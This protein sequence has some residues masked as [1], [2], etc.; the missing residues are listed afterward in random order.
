MIWSRLSFG[1]AV[2]TLILTGCSAT[3]ESASQSSF[4]KRVGPI[5]VTNP[6]YVEHTFKFKNPTARPLSVLKVDKSCGCSNV[7]LSSYELGPGE[8]AELTFGGTAAIGKAIETYHCVLQTDS[9][10]V[11]KLSFQ[12]EIECYPR[13]KSQEGSL[14]FSL[15]SF[16][17]GL[18][19]SGQT[20]ATLH[21][22]AFVDSAESDGSEPEIEVTCAGPFAVEV[23]S[24]ITVENLGAGVVRYAYEIPVIFNEDQNTVERLDDG[25]GF[26]TVRLKE[27]SPMALSV[28]IR[29]SVER[30]V[31]IAPK[32][33]FFGVLRKEG[34]E[35]TRTIT[36]ESKDGKA[37]RLGRI[38]SESGLIEFAA[39]SD[40]AATVHEVTA[41]LRGTFQ[42]GAVR[43]KIVFEL[44]HPAIS[45]LVLSWSAIVTSQGTASN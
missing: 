38:T 7:E 10:Q 24:P 12:L 37:F 26:V 45:Q 31:T 20:D 33:V 9:E 14:H 25:Q 17:D 19:F 6:E 32:P 5:L 35:L 40:D 21:L 43:G 27:S 23:G 2:L 39:H 30:P 15:V 41:T 34:N 18:P 4:T 36:L 42:S 8:S 1:L 16:G 11:P 28:P 29:W 13:L 22:E 44:E 3:R